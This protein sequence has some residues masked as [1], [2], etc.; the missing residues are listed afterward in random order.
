MN[1]FLRTVTLTSALLWGLLL[2]GCASDEGSYPEDQSGEIVV[3]ENDGS[4]GQNSVG[5]DG[6]IQF[7]RPVMEMIGEGL[8]ELQPAHTKYRGDIL[9]LPA[10]GDARDSWCHRSNFCTLARD[11]GYRLIL[12]DMGKSIYT[13]QH[14][15]ETRSDWRAFPTYTWLRDTLIP[16]LQEKYCVLQEDGNNFVIGMSAGAR[17]AMR[18]IQ[19]LPDLFV[20]AAALSGDFD[21]GQMKGDNIYRGFLGN[22]DEF[23]ERW[24]VN[25]NLTSGVERIRIPVFL[26]HG[27]E[28]PLVSYTQSEQFYAALHEAHPDLDVQLH[29]VNA[30]MDG[31][32]FWNSQIKPILAF[33]DASQAVPPESP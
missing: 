11:K 20:G 29:L 12:P 23:P 21:P 30:Q 6:C 24:Q 32:D 7:Q 10:W 9:V 25:E 15:P 31:Y 4:N 5:E 13:S 1:N 14:Y 27:K 8:A 26:A 19:D 2:G 18:L 33:F 3:G 17:G 28:D 16:G 22:Y